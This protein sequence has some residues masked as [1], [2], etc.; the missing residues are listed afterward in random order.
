M[1]NIWVLK[2]NFARF[3][4]KKRRETTN[5]KIQR[6]AQDNAYSET[7]VNSSNYCN[8]FAHRAL[9]LYEFLRTYLNVSVC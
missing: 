5:D 9:T 4:Y 2:L 6:Q 3:C 8:S 7:P 1:K